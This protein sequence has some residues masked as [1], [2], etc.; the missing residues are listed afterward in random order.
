[1]GTFYVNDSKVWMKKMGAY[2]FVRQHILSRSKIFVS[3][4]ND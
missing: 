1:M 4:F 3:N 2:V